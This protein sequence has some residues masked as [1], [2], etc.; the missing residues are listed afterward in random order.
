MGPRLRV[1]VRIRSAGAAALAAPGA[2]DHARHARRDRAVGARRVALPGVARA[3][4]SA[5]DP[6]AP[7][8][9]RR[10]RRRAGD[11]QAR[12]AVRGH[13]QH[14][15]WH[16]LAVLDRHCEAIGRDPSEIERTSGIGT[17]FIRDDRAEAERGFRAAFDRNRV[18][19]P[20]EQQPVGTPEDVA[21]FLA[22]Y[23]ALGYRH[24]VAGFP[25]DYDEESMTRL[26]TEVKPMLE[27]GS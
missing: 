16:R 5:A 9:L 27:K 6:G 20:W 19:R 24:L 15:G 21:E 1:R 8:D 12:G 22:P 10:G 23:A 17:V 7:A 2:P 4:R 3:Q 18:A 25:A 26:V 11:A 13:E 14:R